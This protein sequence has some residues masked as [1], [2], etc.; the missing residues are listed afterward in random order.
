M[1]NPSFVTFYQ[2][3]GK[4]ERAAAMA[5]HLLPW[6]L[7]LILSLVGPSSTA[8][9]DL[10]V[11]TSS[12]S[13]QG[14]HLSSGFG[15]VTAFLGIPYA[16]P[17]VGKLRFQKPVPHQPWS[18]VLEA[19]NFSNSCPQIVISGTPDAETWAANT[20]L[21]E[22]CLYLNVWVPHPRPS[23]PA[24]VL[25]WIYGGAYFIGTTSLVI[26]NAEF[27]AAAENVI[28]VSMNYR[29]GPLGFLSLP[30]AVPGNMGL[31]DQQLAMSWVKQNAAAFGGDPT[32]ITIFGVSAGGASVAFHLLSPG[33]QPLFHRAV[34]ES[35]AS[36]AAWAWLNPEEARRRSQK[37]A[38][39]MGCAQEEVPALVSCL[40]GKNASEFQT[41]QFLVVDPTVV[42]NPP[43]APTTDGEFLTD[44]PRKLLESKNFTAKSIV[45]GTTSDEGSIFVLYASAF[46]NTTKDCLLTREQL[47]KGLQI[48]VRN[49]TSDFIK[50]AAERYSQAEP[51]GP[52]RYR[53]AMGKACS[54]YLF[55]CPV[56]DVATAVTEAGSPVYVYT[57]RHRSTGS[58][59]PEWLGAIHGAEVPYVFGTLTL[60]KGTKEK[61]TKAELELI[62][63]VMRY[64]AEFARSGNPN[65]SD[66]NETKWPV[67]DPAQQNFFV[68]STDPPRVMEPSPAQQ[69]S[70]WKTLPSGASKPGI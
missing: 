8:E 29:L 12:G 41:A 45:I 31:M 63:R 69:C 66:V 17:P 11:V 28:V 15:N 22:D 44:E 58:V 49:A 70:F 54:D 48:T 2:N 21:S 36:V 65:P 64:W 47:L 20:P 4:R 50:A 19:T 35:G 61:H 46:L 59:W 16:E 5:P 30:P 67:Y 51:E 60:L 14:K 62:S 10:V 37:L 52:A 68:L 57:F 6:L 1:C 43:F 53:S 13:V 7:C 32:R 25:V 27:L 39:E 56:T 40:Q 3:K 34:L 9:D 33:S 42:L 23:K 38:K 26:Y 55:V 18:K 24:A